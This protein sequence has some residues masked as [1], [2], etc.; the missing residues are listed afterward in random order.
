MT[1]SPR[2]A[3]GGGVALFATPQLAS[4]AS[5]VSNDAPVMLFG[6]VVTWL[7]AR[8]LPGDLR[9]RTLV[10]LS[11]ALAAIVWCKGTGL[12]AVP[13]VAV[14]VLVAGAGTLPL[15]RRVLRTVV[16]MAVSGALGAWWWLHN[17]LSTG[18]LQ[19]NGYE[20][21]RPPKPFPPGEG[22]SLRTFL[23][24]SWGTITR[25]F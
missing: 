12:P 8:M 1:R 7:A 18:H 2:A 10:G 25:T 22:P 9:R 15:A 4:I 20:Q 23:D 19:P 16:A 6:A 5:S 24:V 13:F 14:V 21:Y 3:L 17:L 11:L